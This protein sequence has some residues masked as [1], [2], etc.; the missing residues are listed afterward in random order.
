[1]IQWTS[2]K[3][4]RTAIHFFLKMDR[5]GMIG[6]RPAYMRRSKKSNHR[7]IESGRKMPRAA[8][9]RDKQ[10]GAAHA[11][12]GQTQRQRMVAQGMNRRMP[13]LTD[14]LTGQFLLSG[15]AQDQNAAAVS[16]YQE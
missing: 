1:M 12:L 9:R 5:M 6:L 7:A 15:T 8:I 11:R 4:A 13:G 3:L 2:S 10:I 14:D 16:V